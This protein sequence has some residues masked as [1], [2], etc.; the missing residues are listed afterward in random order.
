MMNI[1]EPIKSINL[2]CILLTEEGDERNWFKELP[3][4]LNEMDAEKQAPAY[5]CPKT[6]PIIDIDYHS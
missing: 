3:F 1:Y 5:F 4:I 6:N 2:N